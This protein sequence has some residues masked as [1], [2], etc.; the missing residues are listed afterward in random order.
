MTAYAV[1]G[2]TGPFGRLVI[3]SLLERGVAPSDVT[4]VVRSPEKAADL[5][6]LG[7]Q[8][9]HG[10]YDRPETLGTALTGIDV[11]LLVSGSEVGKRVPQHTAVIDAAKAAGVGRIVYTSALRAD[12]TEL[13]VAPE[14]K[15]TE[16]A[17]KASGVPFTILRNGWY[18][19]NY[20]GQLG[21][22][23][24]RGAVVDATGDGRIAAATRAD[25]AEAA[26]AV[27][28]ADGHEG[29]TYEL[30]GTPFTTTELA[31][32]ITEVTGTPVARQSITVAEL[33]AVLRGAGLDEGTAGFVASLDEATARGD[34]DT[35]SGDLPRLLGRPATS[36][37][38]AIRAAA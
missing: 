9:R 10:D 7:V 15:A 32:T 34:L 37:A 29:K 14:H 25:Y 16:A 17:L 28:V 11:L 18:T 26:A 33:A 24:E 12:T 4:A 27:L 31:A 22:Y 38:D 8:V 5:A 23:R 3:A 1:T 6:E 2:A 19:E 30:G 21:S 13:P 35:D 36:L 20:T